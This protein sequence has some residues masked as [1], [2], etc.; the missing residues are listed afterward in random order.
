M[1]SLCTEY[2]RWTDIISWVEFYQR[3]SY[4]KPR[5]DWIL[6]G[7]S[8]SSFWVPRNLSNHMD[9]QARTHDTV[10]VKSREMTGRSQTLPCW[11][12]GEGVKTTEIKIHWPRCA[13][14]SVLSLSKTQPA[15]IHKLIQTQ[16]RYYICWELDFI[17]FH[18]KTSSVEEKTFENFLCK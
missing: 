13:N 2:R 17:H 16:N 4:L 10:L 7:P 14:L 3:Y 1:A 18:F 5:E 8:S 11:L 15:L 6:R 12:G 9:R